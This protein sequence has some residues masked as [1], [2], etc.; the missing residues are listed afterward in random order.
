MSQNGFRVP[1]LKNI[2]LPVNCLYNRG[3]PKIFNS[4]KLILSNKFKSDTLL[5]GTYEC[6]LKIWV[7]PEHHSFQNW[8]SKNASP[9]DSLNHFIKRKMWKICLLQY[10]I[11][12]Y[13]ASKN[14]WENSYT[15]GPLKKESC[16]NV[17]WWFY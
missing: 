7:K 9:I 10:W 13:L 4:T 8:Q 16:Y 2:Y 5:S 12:I 1:C 6:T 17:S 3:L 15:S 11:D 14:N